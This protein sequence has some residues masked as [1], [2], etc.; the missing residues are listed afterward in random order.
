MRFSP[1][2][3]GFKELSSYFAKEKPIGCFVDTSVLFSQT[4]PLDLFNEESERAFEV[5]AD[6]GVSAFT[7]INVRAEFLE[8]H[9]RVLIAECLIDILESW[10]LRWTVF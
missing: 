5:L 4:Y 2:I 1:S 7:N 10:G 8:N 6:H 9:R 3:C